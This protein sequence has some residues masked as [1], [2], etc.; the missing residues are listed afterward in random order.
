MVKEDKFIGWINKNDLLPDRSGDY[1]VLYD[2][3]KEGVSRYNKRLVK[4]NTYW[5]DERFLKVVIT[6]WRPL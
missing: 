1:Q 2:N 4:W 6:H 3:R 5:S